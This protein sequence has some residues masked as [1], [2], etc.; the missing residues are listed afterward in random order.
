MDIVKSGFIRG[1]ATTT[2]DEYDKRDDDNKSHHATWEI[3]RKLYENSF[4][5]LKDSARHWY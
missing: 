3:L 2:F 4:S 1:S 5:S